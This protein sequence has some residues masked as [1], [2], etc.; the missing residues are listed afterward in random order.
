M[1]KSDNKHSVTA[2]QTAAKTYA[3]LYKKKKLC[4][5]FPCELE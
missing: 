2:K 4:D 5:F 1:K 3:A